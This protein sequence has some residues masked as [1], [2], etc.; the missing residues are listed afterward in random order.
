MEIPF[1]NIGT[2]M[3]VVLLTLKNSVQFLAVVDTGSESS[4]MEVKFIKDNKEVF[5]KEKTQ[6]K[7]SLL[8][9]NGESAHPLVYASCDIIG[10]EQDMKLRFE[11]VNLEFASNSFEEK[12]NMKISALIGSDMLAKYNAVIDYDKNTVTFNNI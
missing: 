5:D 1:V 8:G 9:F 6:K 12:Y 2:D 10:K 7:V 3:P 11:A 4:L